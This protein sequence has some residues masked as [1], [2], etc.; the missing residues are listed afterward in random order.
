MKTF[1][2][3]KLK[4]TIVAENNT[5]SFEEFKNSFAKIK[6]VNKEFYFWEGMN[7]DYA[8]IKGI[9]ASKGIKEIPAKEE[10]DSFV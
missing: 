6:K 5:K 4:N 10:L 1:N 3:T 7:C 8:R 2:D 9:A